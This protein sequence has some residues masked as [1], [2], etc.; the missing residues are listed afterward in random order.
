MPE[1]SSLRRVQYLGLAVVLAVSSLGAGA[2]KPGKKKRKSKS[3]GVTTSQT[4]PAPTSPGT[5]PVQDNGL[6]NKPPKVIL[7]QVATALRGATSLHAKGTM[8][9]GRDRIAFDMTFTKQGAAK[10]KVRGPILRKNVT[11]EVI[12]VNGKAYLRGRQ[13]WLAAGGQAAARRMGSKWMVVPGRQNPG[14]GNLSMA[15]FA[16][17]LRPSGRVVKLPPAML[18]GQRVIRLMDMADRSV[19]FVATT[20]KPYPMRIAEKGGRQ[21]MDF[22]NFDAPVTITR[23]LNVVTRP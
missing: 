3:G 1:Y 5:A 11:V 21:F 12:L 14:G 15:G 20:G 13:L 2:C 4:S 7:T 10:G 8:K 22:D 16:K 23:P 9:D 17:S 18:R 6:A 19:L